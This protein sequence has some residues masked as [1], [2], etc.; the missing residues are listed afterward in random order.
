MIADISS[1]DCC[2]EIAPLK[3]R[4]MALPASTGADHEPQAAS[5]QH[6]AGPASEY[7][8]FALA[9]RQFD[10]LLPTIETLSADLQ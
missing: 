2:S 4:S 8:R 6:Q 10:S 9:F 3:I 7:H 5:D 1:L